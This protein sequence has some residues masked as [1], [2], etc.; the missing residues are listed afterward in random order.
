MKMLLA[1]SL[2]MLSF[3]PPADSVLDQSGSTGVI[4][5]TWRSRLSESWVRREGERWVS[6]E[7]QRDGARNRAI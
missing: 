4:A 5:G 6:I 7:L 3:V 1:T 2:L